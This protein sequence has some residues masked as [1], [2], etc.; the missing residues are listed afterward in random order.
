AFDARLCDLDPIEGVA[1]YIGKACD[2]PSA[3]LITISQRQAALKYG[4]LPAS[5]S[6]ARAAGESRDGCDAAQSSKCVSTSSFTGR[7]RTARESPCCPW[8]RSRPE[9]RTPIRE[10]PADP[11][12][13]A[14]LLSMLRP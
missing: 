12:R 11:E 2:G 4:C 5:P 9:S 6:M 8:C 1:M 13:L 7:S 14:P 10:S 3:P